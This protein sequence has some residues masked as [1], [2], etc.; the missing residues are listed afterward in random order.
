M[1]IKDSKHMKLILR[2]NTCIIFNVFKY[3]NHGH[4]NACNHEQT[5][6]TKK[7]VQK[8][9]TTTT[10]ATTAA[11]TVIIIKRTT[12]IVTTEFYNKN[13]THHFQ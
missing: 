2:A 7:K 11:T 13:K 9:E 4:D 3:N 8:S 1:F 5:R 10:T 12:K 6:R